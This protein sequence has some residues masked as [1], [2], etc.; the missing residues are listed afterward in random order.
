MEDLLAGRWIQYKM[1]SH[2]INSRRGICN[3]ISVILPT[4][5]P[6]NIHEAVRS[7]FESCRENEIEIII[8]ADFQDDNLSK[9]NDVLWIYQ[10]ERKGVISAVNEGIGYARGEYYFC[11]ND[12]AVLARG[13]LYNLK[14]FCEEH[15]DNIIACPRHFPY[16]P[17]YYYGK[18][19]AAFPFA[20]R[21][22]INKIGGFF[23]ARYKA[24]YADPDLS[25]R[26]YEAGYEVKECPNASLVHNN[27]MACEAHKINVSK[28]VLSDRETF[29]KRW[30]HL[31][32]FVDP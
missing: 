8:I 6:E 7:I 15:E 32:E 4:V 1:L 20:H 17:F 14:K 22:L 16:F 18:F 31:G 5:R 2:A 25:L 29:R 9:R 13:C 28:Y 30:D 27:S 24:F 21:E 23:D 12:E 19:F 3:M 11:T 10:P 26:A